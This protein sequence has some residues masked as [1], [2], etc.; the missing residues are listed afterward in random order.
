MSKRNKELVSRVDEM[1]KR[2]IQNLKLEKD[3]E[4]ISERNKELEA[5]I[6]GF[7]GR[8]LR[9]LDS[10]GTESCRQCLALGEELRSTI[11]QNEKHMLTTEKFQDE[12]D[13]LLDRYNVLENQLKKA[14]EERENDD[15]YQDLNVRCIELEEQLRDSNELNEKKTAQ[16]ASLKTKVC[17]LEAYA[18]ETASDLE[19]AES[20]LAALKAQG[21]GG[22]AEMTLLMGRCNQLQNELK[23]AHKTTERMRQ[24]LANSQKENIQM[25]EELNDSMNDLVVNINVEDE[26]ADTTRK[27]AVKELKEDLD[28][29]TSE[30]EELEILLKKAIEESEKEKRL[31]GH[32]EKD[33]DYFE[34]VYNECK[35]S[36]AKVESD[37]DATKELLKKANDEKEEFERQLQIEKHVSSSLK[38]SRKNQD[39]DDSEENELEELYRQARDELTEVEGMLFEAEEELDALKAKY[40]K[41]EQ[42]SKNPSSK[43]EEV[44]EINH[45]LQD[46]TRDELM[47]E[48]HKALRKMQE[49]QFKVVDL[50]ETNMILQAQLKS[51]LT[52]KEKSKAP[53]RRR[54]NKG[55]RGGFWSL[56]NGGDAAAKNNDNDGNAKNGENG[57]GEG[58]FAFLRG[59]GRRGDASNENSADEVSTD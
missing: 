44:E 5:R 27:E 58:R 38:T 6:N 42:E 23:E 32:V 52:F 24:E 50:Q 37:L 45:D 13:Q 9:K 41:L 20:L 53:A 8:S 16:L 28:R 1:R 48:T 10:Q 14:L 18:D 55:E 22:G 39:T 29:I 21:I 25:S 19:Q 59:R 46:L 47:K 3:F 49:T 57:N 34:K 30:K 36:M 33:R 17:D 40:E 56:G 2:N 26:K 4:K 35:S 51:S 15:K 7:R 12:H 31:K 11:E 54:N 43:D